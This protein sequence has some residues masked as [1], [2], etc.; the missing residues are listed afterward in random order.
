MISAPHQQNH[1]AQDRPASVVE[2][3][4]GAARTVGRHQIQRRSDPPRHPHAQVLEETSLK[5]H[6]RQDSQSHYTGTTRQ[7]PGGKTTQNII[8]SMH[9]ERDKKFE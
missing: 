6:L 3:P 2:D 4:R 9:Q 7:I 5:V 8:T 1:N